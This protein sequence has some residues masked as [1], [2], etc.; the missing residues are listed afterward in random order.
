MRGLNLETKILS[1]ELSTF[2]TDKKSRRIRVGTEVVLVKFYE[3]L[4]A[5]YAIESRTYWTNTKVDTLQVLGAENVQTLVNNTTL[6][7]RLH[8]TGTYGGGHHQPTLV[9][10]GETRA[11]R[12]CHVVSTWS[13]T[14]SSI[15]WSSSSV[16]AMSS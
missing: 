10:R 15:A 9:C 4:A 6:F 13:A 8:R 11:P 14:Q 2:L 7:T 3:Q 12:E 1:D 5:S 16:Y